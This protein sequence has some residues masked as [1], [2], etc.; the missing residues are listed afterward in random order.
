MQLQARERRELV[1]SRM[2]AHPDD[3][4]SLEMAKIGKY[5]LYVNARK[6]YSPMVQAPPRI[7][8]NRTPKM[9]LG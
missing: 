9:N 2:G 5:V 7:L 8:T 4:C 6:G 3:I 1:I